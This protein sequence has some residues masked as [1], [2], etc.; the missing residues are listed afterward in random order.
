VTSVV[1]LSDPRCHEVARVGPKAANLSRLAAS[2]RVPP[3]FVIPD[4][5]STLDALPAPLIADV[6][7]A[8]RLLATQTGAALPRVAV[9]SS[10]VDEDGAQASFAGQHATY[11]NVSGEDAIID[12]IVRCAASAGSETALAYRAAREVATG[13]GGARMAVLVQH[14]VAA[15]VALIAFSANPV[16]GARGEVV[17]NASWG[18]GEAV[19]S[20]LVTPDMYTVRQGG[21]GPID[22]YV[23]DKRTMTVPV[24]DGSAEA[25]V[26]EERR[27]LRCLDD[28]QV[29]EVAL[30][31]S[32]L[33]AEMGWPVDIE[34]AYA[35]GD[36][37]LLQCRPITTL[38]D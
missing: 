22:A 35:G 7:A 32:A 18:L 11:L 20:G 9:R 1:W 29:H 17:I 37:Y 2:H 27:L 19:V 6:R 36:L 3:G 14:L 33:E 31:A 15:D 34:A 5:A 13:E 10:A 30:L 28:A 16:T 12:A 23:G 21:D 26:P 4:L 38:A 25:P 24:E 8:Y